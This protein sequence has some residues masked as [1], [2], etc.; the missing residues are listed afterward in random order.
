MRYSYKPL[1]DIPAVS[2][3]TAVD[4]WSGE[5]E[6]YPCCAASGFALPYSEDGYEII[7]NIHENPELVKEEE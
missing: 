4:W 2:S 1:W 3:T 6:H 7:G 5:E